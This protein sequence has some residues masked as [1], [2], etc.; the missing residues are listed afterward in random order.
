MLD[1]LE[2]RI[3]GIRAGSQ[4]LIHHVGVTG[5]RLLEVSSR[6]SSRLRYTPSTRFVAHRLAVADAHVALVQADREARLELVDSAVEPATWRRFT[7]IGA[8]RRVLKPDLYAE[9]A[10]GKDMVRAWF[11]EVDLGTEHIPTLI[12]KCRE[13]EAY[14]QTGIEQDRHDSFPIVVWSLLHH[15]P[16]KAE[17]RRNALAHAI[18]SDHRL[19]GALFRI[20]S[21]EGVLPLI[22]NGGTL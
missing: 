10:V 5:S 6:R 11:L 8:A 13:Y 14:R 4:G 2:R 9:T 16:A 15:D 1:T 20:T 18:A 3:G 22:Q 12:N 21:P 17:N 19:P 7:G